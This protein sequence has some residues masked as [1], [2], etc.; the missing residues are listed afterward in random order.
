MYVLFCA[1]GILFL[2]ERILFLKF[3][4]I[5]QDFPSHRIFRRMYKA[6][7]IDKNKTNYIV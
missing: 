2:N 5:F 6:L 3:C 1:A 4:K 7:N